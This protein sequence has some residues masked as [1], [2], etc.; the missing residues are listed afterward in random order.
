[1]DIT[2]LR[3]LAALL[4]L[5]LAGGIAGRKLWFVYRLIRLG[6]GPVP[7][8]PLSRGLRHLLVQVVGHTKVF[9]RFT[10]GLLHL[11][12]FWGFLVLLTTILQAFGEAFVP[13]WTLPVVGEAA[14]LVALQDLFI[15]LVL[16][17]ILLAL[18]LRLVVRPWRLQTQDQFGAYLI[19]GL[20]TGIMTTL[21]LTRAAGIAL[22]RAGWAQ[23]AFASRAVAGGLDTLPEAA[24]R[25]I[26]E[27]AWWVHLGLILYFLTWIPE[28]KHLHLITL[29][30]NVLLQRAR[31]RG[32]LALLDIEGAHR[33]GASRAEHFTWKDNLDAFAC[34]E[35][36]RCTEV[37]PANNT[38]KELDPRR[39]HTDLRK[40]LTAVGAQL[41]AGRSSDDVARPPLVGEVFSEAFL[42][43]CLSCGACVEECPA[44]NDHID[45]IVEMRRYLVM[46]EARLPEPMTQALRSLE[47]RGHP[48]RGAAVT[49][50]AWTAGA[51]VARF[52]LGGRAEWLLWV[53]CAAALNEG[54]HASLRALVGLL[55]AAGVEVGILG[56]EETCTGD[57]AR[58]IGHE[59]LFQTLARQNIATL[60]RHGVTR[61]VTP[62]PHC[63]NTLKNEYPALGG[64]YEVWHHTQLLARF[65]D[66]GKLR[67]AR[68]L[69]QRITFHDPCYLG[70]H[71]GEYAAP[72]RILDAIPQV[73]RV[74]MA[75]CR[76]RAFC[77]GAG[78]GLYWHEDR[79]GERVSHVRS[80]HIAATGADIVATACPFC[81]LML[82]DAGK[83]TDARAH[84]MDVAELL[85]RGTTGG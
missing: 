43:Q 49:R 59:Y 16:V 54:N 9:R 2:W 62:C 77:C 82:E 79:A 33:L 76:D 83:A 39:L 35:C 58:R 57:P 66:E 25:G 11:F 30:P 8:A 40:Q 7:L 14:W 80:R 74:E 41:L 21:L 31:P 34:M 12:I 5:A 84:P 29:I 50:T 10:S 85:L 47:A 71:N 81:A 37:C 63:Y 75:R 48:F 24:A 36:G 13:G 72:R 69:A 65:I 64:R 6:H 55:R 28:G 46:E 68:G 32:A 56:E 51:E 18:Y 78:G 73:R 22:G 52:D 42:W 67:P 26:F 38:G 1:M 17:G 45:K 44:D 3:G 53:G 19:L 70:R 23:A 60:A 4:L 20:I 15:V 61:I 27:V